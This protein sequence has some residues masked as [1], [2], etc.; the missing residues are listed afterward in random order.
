ML[1]APLMSDP[2]VLDLFRRCAVE[3]CNWQVFVST[4]ED[5]PRC[6]GHGGDPIAGYC[7]DEFGEEARYYRRQVQVAVPGLEGA[8]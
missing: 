6:R 3:G 5:D 1:P 8:K 7:I 2:W 4:A